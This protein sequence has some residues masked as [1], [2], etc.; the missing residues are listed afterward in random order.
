MSHSKRKNKSKTNT[1]KHKSDYKNDLLHQLLWTFHFSQSNFPKE[2]EP[3]HFLTNMVNSHWTWLV[4][5]WSF[6][7]AD[8]LLGFVL[9]TVEHYILVKRKRG[10]QQPKSENSCRCAAAVNTVWL[11]GDLQPW[12]IFP[13]SPSWKTL[14]KLKFVDTAVWWTFL[15]C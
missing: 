11:Y 2:T 14:D 7:K 3:F 15:N 12:L 5:A 9:R 6:F 8:M 13:C 10:V 4:A 1:Q